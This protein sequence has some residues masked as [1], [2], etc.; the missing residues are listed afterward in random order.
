MMN[1]QIEHKQQDQTKYQKP[2]VVFVEVVP[3]WCDGSLEP[4]KGD[5]ETPLVLL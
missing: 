4:V 3:V 2:D 5:N 1:Q